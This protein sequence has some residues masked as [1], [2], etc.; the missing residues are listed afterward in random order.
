MFP[1]ILELTEPITT[2]LAAAPESGLLPKLSNQASFYLMT[3]LMVLFTLL[4]GIPIY[5]SPKFPHAQHGHDDHDDHE[6]H[7][8]DH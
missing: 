8:G 5:H 7:D 6:G 1:M 4:A 3:A 2:M